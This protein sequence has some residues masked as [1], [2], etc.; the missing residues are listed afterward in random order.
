[1]SAR[2]HAS[3][4][5]SISAL[6]SVATCRDTH[7]TLPARESSVRALLSCARDLVQHHTRELRLI[8]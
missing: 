1:M 2:D 3:D 8:G 4:S 6:G 5:A 7:A